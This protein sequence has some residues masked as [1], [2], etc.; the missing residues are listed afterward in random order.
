MS[1]EAK[2]WEKHLALK[3]QVTGVSHC[4]S[5]QTHFKVNERKIISF[6]PLVASIDAIN[7]LCKKK[8]L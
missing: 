7:L 8:N 3:A 4:N 2:Q 6:L 5:G 1:E